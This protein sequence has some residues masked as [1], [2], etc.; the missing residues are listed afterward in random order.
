MLDAVARLWGKAPSPNRLYDGSIDWL[1]NST[2]ELLLLIQDGNLR[3]YMRYMMVLPTAAALYLVWRMDWGA[4]V[5]PDNFAGASFLLV[6]IALM[7]VGAG[8][9]T[10]L[11]RRRIP[12]ILALGTMGYGI[13][14]LYLL[15]KAP[16]LALTQIMVESASVVLFLLVFYYLP[17]LKPVPASAAKKIRD[18]GIAIGLGV[19]TTLVMA[20]AMNT[21]KFRT[22]ADYF[23]RTSKP[24]A[25][26]KNVVNAIIVDYR[27][28][29]TL[30]EIT[31]LVIA[32]IAVY[33]LL[34]LVGE[35]KC[36]H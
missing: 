19:C 31:V 10:A 18:W 25:G 27:G 9:A 32:G 14:G 24:V 3:R 34:R 1:R 15:L 13:A 6:V 20:A 7:I 17:E 33:A 29:D 23:M 4:N 22:I 26:F 35:M 8:L 30:G 21:H 36:D 2:W 16:D 12:A 28:Y 5:F 11:F